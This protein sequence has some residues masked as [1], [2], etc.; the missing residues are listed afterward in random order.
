MAIH[1]G[2]RIEFRLLIG[3]KRDTADLS[4]VA[5]RAFHCDPSQAGVSALKAI[6]KM[7]YVVCEQFVSD[8]T[9]FLTRRYACPNLPM[10]P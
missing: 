3:S 8:S 6:Y 1:A 9:S 5:K 2:S 10:P 7:V 4:V